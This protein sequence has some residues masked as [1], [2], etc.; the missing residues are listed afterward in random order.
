MIKWKIRKLFLSGLLEGLT[1][2]ESFSRDEVLG[3]PWKVGDEYEEYG[4]RSKVRIL[5]VTRA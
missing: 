3:A 1:V 4:T 5:S 2:E